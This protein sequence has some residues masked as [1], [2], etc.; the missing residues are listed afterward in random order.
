[1]MIKRYLIYL[2]LGGLG[3]THLACTD[4]DH[5]ASGRQPLQVQAEMAAVAA[6]RAVDISSGGI[7]DKTSFT[8]NDVVSIVNNGTTHKY[9]YTAAGKWVPET[10]GQYFKTAGSGTYTASY[11]RPESSNSIPADQ[12][13]PAGFRGYYYYNLS[14]TVTLSNSN[15]LSFTGVNALKPTSARITVHV[16]YPEERTPVSVTLTGNGICTGNTSAMETIQC[17]YMNAPTHDFNGATAAAK[18]KEQSW[19]ALIK[20][21]ISLSYTITIKCTVT[22]TGNNEVEKT[23]TYTQSAKTLSGGTN[24]VYNF[25]FSDYPKLESVQVDDFT[26]LT[27]GE[28]DAGSAQ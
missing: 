6:P 27:G 10:A 9:T 24:Y 16:S 14:S 13:T 19:T 5:S 20:E 11:T 2:F 1:M 4:E 7:L 22:D 25:S 17:L 3:C 21:G 18:A 15:L 23:G 12:R 28:I 26:D 8:T